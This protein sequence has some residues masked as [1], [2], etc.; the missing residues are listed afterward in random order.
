[1]KKE[2]RYVMF[3]DVP[4]LAFVYNICDIFQKVI[5]LLPDASYVL[6]DKCRIY[7]EMLL[8]LCRVF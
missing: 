5:Q 7:R 2:R 8:E 1:M 4:E 6:W 3:V